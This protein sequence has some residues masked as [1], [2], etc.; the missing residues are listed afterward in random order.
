MKKI[1]TFFL[2][3]FIGLS[4]F[5]KDIPILNYTYE[6]KKICIDN[7][8][9]NGKPIC[10]ENIRIINS[11]ESD[12]VFK[13]KGKKIGTTEDIEISTI[14]VGKYDSELKFLDIPLKLFDYIVLTY[15]GTDF[16]ISKVTCEHK[17]MYIYIE[18]KTVSGSSLNYS[19][20]AVIKNKERAFVNSKI[21][22]AENFVS[23]KD[24]IQMEDRESGIIIGKG[25]YN[26]YGF[27]FKIKING[28]NV[29]VDYYDFDAKRIN[30]STCDA[31]EALL[32]TSS[33]KLFETIEK[34]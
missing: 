1:V 20:S 8:W 9:N 3:V 4:A 31:I 29:S 26:K 30:V 24:V 27:T 25:K 7:T 34:N 22:I 6:G 21:W 2:T 23:A 18:T 13:I 28:N 33:E 17:D 14:Y 32:K 10:S 12:Y 15:E 16:E 11:A 5:S 19:Y